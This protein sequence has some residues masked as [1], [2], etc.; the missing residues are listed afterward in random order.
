MGCR[1]KRVDQLEPVETGEIEPSTTASTVGPNDAVQVAVVDDQ[2]VVLDPSTGHRVLLNASAALVFTAFDTDRKVDDVV[3]QLVDETGMPADV[4]TSDVLATV[5]RLLTQGLLTRADVAALPHRAVSVPAGRVGEATDDLTVGRRW[6]F[7]SGVRSVA[8]VAMVAR[9][10]PPGRAGEIEATLDALERVDTPTGD[11]VVTRIDIIAGTT[12]ADD[13]SAD[14]AVRMLVDGA[15]RTNLVPAGSLAAYLFDL[16]DAEVAVR[17]AGLRFHAGAVERNSRVVVVVGQSGHGKSTLTAALVQAG[18]SYITDEVVVVDSATFDVAPY[19]R[20]LDLDQRSLDRL[21]VTGPDLVTGARKHKVFPSRL[22]RI[23]AGGQVAAI[24]V[25]TGDQPE[26]GRVVSD[27]AASEAVMA[28]LALTFAET[29][30]DPDALVS[31]G[32]LCSTVP[33]ARLYRAP[34]GE[35]VQAVDEL[36]GAAQKSTR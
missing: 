17:A 23:S 14:E 26:E 3:E 20:P 8:G 16:L 33:V 31:L 10:E 13:G 11:G 19:A 15:E 4:L 7:D 35:M 30:E 27:L 12:A 6:S 36:M 28:M 32:R 24:L 29:F 5:D 21:G 25:L 22:G 1:G 18:W 9:V 2:L 34:L